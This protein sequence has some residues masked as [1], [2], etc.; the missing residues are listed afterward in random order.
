MMPQ[1]VNISKRIAVLLV[2]MTV[3]VTWPRVIAAHG[4]PR[5]P[6]VR[7][8]NQRRRTEDRKTKR[9]EQH[10]LQGAETRDAKKSAKDSHQSQ[11]QSESGTPNQQTSPWY[12]F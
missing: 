11:T 4:R 6:L 2:M 3:V 10:D 5:D 8:E 12:G 1:S 7:M 9:R